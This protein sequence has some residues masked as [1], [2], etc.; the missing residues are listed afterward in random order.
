MLQKYLKISITFFLFNFCVSTGLTPC[1]DAAGTTY[2]PSATSCNN[3]LDDAICVEIFAAA[4]HTP[5]A[6]VIDD[7]CINPDMTR[8]SLEC[9]NRC[10]MCCER[11][12][13]SCGDSETSPID[14]ALN[15]QRCR[16]P[17]WTI[18]MN[19]YCPGTCGT[20]QNRTCRDYNDRCIDMITICNH[21]VFQEFM[22]LRCAQTCDKCAATTTT[23]TAISATI[24]PSTSLC[25]DIATNCAANARFCNNPAYFNVMTQKCP[26]TCNRCPG[27]TII[28][29]TT[30]CADTY[31]NFLHINVDT[32]VDHVICVK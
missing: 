1:L 23:S 13:A 20:C 26:R 11:A 18:V 14:C 12:E 25:S 28:S 24:A 17:A 22:T 3:E 27:S 30:T 7:D 31:P 6:I 21:I 29:N 19:T 5:G 4:D 9:A 16:D 10:G 2:L 32:V 8:I 15:A